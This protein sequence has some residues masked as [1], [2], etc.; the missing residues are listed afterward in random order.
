MILPLPVCPP[1][2]RI[3]AV[4]VPDDE[5]VAMI[6]RANRFRSEVGELGWDGFIVDSNVRARLYWNPTTPELPADQESLADKI[7]ALLGDSRLSA[8]QAA[9]L[10][11][12]YFPPRGHP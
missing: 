5:F 12:E 1:A 11:R 8:Q 9:Q 3:L 4:V 10:E 7:Y 2:P 6:A